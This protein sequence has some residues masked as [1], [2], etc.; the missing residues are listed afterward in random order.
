[1][2][3]FI[4]KHC[5]GYLENGLRIPLSFSFGYSLGFKELDYPKM[6]KEAD[7]KMYEDKRGRK[8]EKAR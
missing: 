2:L 4:R 5:L 7:A 1:M 6:L 8:G 3:D